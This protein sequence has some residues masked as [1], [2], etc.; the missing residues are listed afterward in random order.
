MNNELNQ[1]NEGVFAVESFGA[2]KKVM[3]SNINISNVT[4]YLYQLD[5]WE[6]SLTKEGADFLVNDIGID[7]VVD[8][9]F[10]EVNKGV[11]YKNKDKESIRNWLT[12]EIDKAVKN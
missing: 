8:A 2:N 6:I 11:D 1:N 3:I 12:S 4:D 7:V 5:C 10:E 9:I